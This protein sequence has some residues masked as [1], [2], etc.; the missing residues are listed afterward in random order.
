[1][2]SGAGTAQFGQLAANHGLTAGHPWVEQRIKQ[3]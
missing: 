3:V 2:V 1:M